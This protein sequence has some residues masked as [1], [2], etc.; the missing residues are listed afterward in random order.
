MAG[1]RADEVIA[2]ASVVSA[3]L[4]AD[5]MASPSFSVASELLSDILRT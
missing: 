3:A 1:C 4:F 5:H 2:E